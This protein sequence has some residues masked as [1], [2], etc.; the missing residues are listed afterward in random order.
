MTSDN[1]NQ[2][3]GVIL[4]AGI[5]SRMRSSIPKPL[6]SLCGRTLL[7]QTMCVL[8]DAGVQRLVVV[9]SPLI[10]ADPAFAEVVGED[11]GV[12]IQ[13][14]PRGT[15]DALL[16]ASDAVD[17]ASQILVAN[18]DMPLVTP[19]TI[20]TMLSTHTES[21][22]A[23]TLLTGRGS[24]PAGFGRVRRDTGGGVTAIVEEAEADEAALSLDEFNA[25]YYCM[26][27]PAAWGLLAGL[28]PAGNGEIYITDAVAA[29][30]DSGA[31]V[32]AVVS[33]DPS[34]LSG[35]NDR[36]E[37]AEAEALLRDRIRR[38]WMLEGVS[39]TDPATTYIDSDVTIGQDTIIRPN[40]HL[41]GSTEV[42]MNAEIGP[43]TVLKDSRVGDDASVVSSHVESA[44]IG[45]R[46]TIGP[47]SHLRPG[48]L[49]GPDAHIGNYAEV[50]NAII[51]AE[52]KIGHFSYVGD[53]TVGVG[54]N[55]GAGTVTCNY[56]GDS[57]H[58]TV[59]GAN[60]FIGSGSMLVAPVSIGPGAS[61]GAGSVVTH[62]VPAGVRVA[63]VP[64]RPMPEVDS[65]K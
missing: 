16:T 5:G 7:G 9:V 14:E 38:H 21:G 31:S 62:D 26:D 54:A 30:V 36:T 24:V 29:A 34:E 15:G 63:G 57:K 45:E 50:K 46:A 12:A 18:A 41:L 59:I 51:G 65:E 47:F 20:R 60:A 32:G 42:G 37:L 44:R 52:A 64:A 8:K 35:V 61:T 49:I 53:A 11:A 28:T 39:M 25:G 40:S 17:G 13:T 1:E 33:D 22:A 27:A 56:D 4:A 6:H 23:I 48:T 55:I 43:G 3:V 2:W 58:Q 10:A 19:K